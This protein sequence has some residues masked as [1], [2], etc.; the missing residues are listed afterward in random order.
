VYTTLSYH[1]SF[2]S[3]LPLF[4][5]L[6]P[7]YLTL[8]SVLLREKRRKAKEEEA[9]D[10]EDDAWSA[11][12]SSDAVRTRRRELLPSKLA[13]LVISELPEQV[14]E[15]LDFVTEVRAYTEKEPSGDVILEARRLKKELGLDDTT[16]LAKLVTAL[17]DTTTPNVTKPRVNLLK[18]VISGA[19]T[20][21]LL[22]ENIE[23]LA[24]KNPEVMKKVLTLVKSCYDN[25]IL[26][27]EVIVQW[28]TS[29]GDANVRAALKKMVDW[30]Q[31]AEEDD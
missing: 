21:K 13:S 7:S 19:A 3:S 11:D 16:F 23:K 22:L 18:K 4:H 12:T 31:A 2:S 8:W 30:L 20:Q 25:D 5:C 27:E 29:P 17:F 9:H 6:L 24:T 1:S 26:E 15:P 10:D 28:H 14:V